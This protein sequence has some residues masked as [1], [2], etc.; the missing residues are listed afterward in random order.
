MLNR[1]SRRMVRK[2]LLGSVEFRLGDETALDAS[3]CF[4]VVITPF[5]L[6]LFAE[7]TLQTHL[8]PRLLSALSP[9]GLWLVTDFVKPH[10]LWQKA[11]LWSM[12]R[13]FRLTAGIETRQLAD[14]QRLLRQAGLTLRECQTKV[15]GLVSTEVYSRPDDPAS[16]GL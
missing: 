9:C 5:V 12:I 14:W 6:D 2:P 10:P 8:I 1:A 11:I 7:E 15:G 16:G 4:D 3:E 13:F